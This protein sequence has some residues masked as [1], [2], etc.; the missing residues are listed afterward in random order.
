[1]RRRLERGGAAPPAGRSTRHEH[2]DRI[3]NGDRDAPAPAAG[4]AVLA[5]G[6]LIVTGTFLPWLSVFE[7]LQT[8]RGIEGP[9]GRALAILGTV[10]MIAG[11]LLAVRGGR[12]LGL[13]IAIGGAAAAAFAGYLVAQLLVTMHGLDGMMLTKLGPGLFVSAAG[14]VLVAGS[15]LLPETGAETAEECKRTTPPSSARVLTN[16]VALASVGAGVIHLAVAPAH[17]PK[18]VPFGVFFVVLGVA[19]LAYAGLVWTRPTR[20][21]L[22][23]GA[24]AN[25]GVVALW[26]LSRSAGIPIGPEHWSPEA[27]GFADVVCSAY[28]ALIVV[29][30]WAV[31]RDGDRELRPATSALAR[32]APVFVGAPLTVAA[33]LS[34]AGVLGTGPMHM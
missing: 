26:L 34:A 10:A 1:M 33:V 29:A 11:G 32:F 30:T 23:T 18:W 16:A 19:Q 6:A 20:S 5:G 12:R 28:E 14:A 25:A 7:G 9:N 21:L 24:I 13:G 22:V 17:L 3:R 31:L 4:L 27:I 2:R 8:I 15:I